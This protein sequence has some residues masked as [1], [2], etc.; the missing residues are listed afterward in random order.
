M[1][2]IPLFSTSQIKMEI[3]MEFSTSLSQ[4]L[5]SP[6]DK[7]QNCFRKTGALSRTCVSARLEQNE[8]LLQGKGS[9]RLRSVTPAHGTSAGVY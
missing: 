9:K 7:L 1:S 6:V 5:L 3:S 4:L 2:S 8:L